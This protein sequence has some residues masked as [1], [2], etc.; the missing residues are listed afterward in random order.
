M[1]AI[2]KMFYRVESTKNSLICAVNV[3]ELKHKHKSLY[4]SLV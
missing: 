2:F 4:F 3:N 1:Y